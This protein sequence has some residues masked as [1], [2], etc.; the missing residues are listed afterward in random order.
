MPDAKQAQ[1]AQPAH[2]RQGGALR[3]TES[4]GDGALVALYRTCPRCGLSLAERFRASALS[5]CP[6][7]IARRRTLVEMVQS[8]HPTGGLHATSRRSG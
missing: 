2:V 3:A 6:R 7:C 1:T 4:S 8:R 5:H